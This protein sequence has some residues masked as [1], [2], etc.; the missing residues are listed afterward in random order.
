MTA[1]VSITAFP[2]EDGSLQQKVKVSLRIPSQY[3]DSPPRPGDESIQIEEREGMT[4]YS[5]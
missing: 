2:D 3:Q 4:I 1:P 5:T